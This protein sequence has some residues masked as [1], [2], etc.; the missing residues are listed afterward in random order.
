MLQSFLDNGIL[1]KVRAAYMIHGTLVK[2]K[3]IDEDDFQTTPVEWET[4]AM[5]LPPVELPIEVEIVKARR[6]V[7]QSEALRVM[8]GLI[9]SK[10][11]TKYPG[12]L[13]LF[14]H[15]KANIR[16]ARE[17]DFL[18]IN[19]R[20]Q[21]EHRYIRNP[22][23]RLKNPVLR[24]KV[25]TEASLLV[26]PALQSQLYALLDIG[27]DGRWMQSFQ[28]EDPQAKHLYKWQSDH[29]ARTDQ[30]THTPEQLLRLMHNILNYT[31]L[32]PILLEFKEDGDA[33][34]FSVQTKGNTGTRDEKPNFNWL[35]DNSE[36]EY[37]KLGSVNSSPRVIFTGMKITMIMSWAMNSRI[38]IH[39]LAHY[40]TFCIPTSYRL[41]KGEV[42]LSFKQY[43]ELFC[44]HGLLYMGVYARMLVKFYHI[45]EDWLLDSWDD[46]GLKY[47]TIDDLKLDAV[48]KAITGH[49]KAQG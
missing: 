9:T 3:D 40:F 28:L 25:S 46:A 33:C 23:W 42:S 24:H 29:S 47:I 14:L 22:L 31:G 35:N 19:N 6:F 18:R 48:E 8:R 49:Y 15:N 1:N 16:F 45:K 43:E 12:T 39:E 41:N 7:S 20:D 13:G 27:H 44:G 21:I 36:S 4:R 5:D 2:I 37:E 34:M 10:W 26:T 30:L 32:P 11:N 38:L 17:V